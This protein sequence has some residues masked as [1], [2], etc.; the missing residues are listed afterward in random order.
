MRGKSSERSIKESY[1]LDLIRFKIGFG[2]TTAEQ[3]NGGENVTF[4]RFLF[5]KLTFLK[6]LIFDP[7][8]I[9]TTVSRVINVLRSISEILSSRTKSVSE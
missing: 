7:G 6:A 3:S 8:G 4:A 5:L 1:T 2:K 9:F